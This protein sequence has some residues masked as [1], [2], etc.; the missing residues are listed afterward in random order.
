[1][2]KDFISFIQLAMVIISF[3]VAFI[4]TFYNWRTGWFGKLISI[5]LFLTT[6]GVYVSTL[7]A[8]GIMVNFPH[9]FRTGLMVLY[10]IPAGIY[11]GIRTGFAKV[12]FHT[13]DLFHL[14]PA[15]FYIVNFYPSI[16][17][18]AAV[19][20]ELINPKNMRSFEEGIIF[21]PY[22]VLWITEVLLFFYMAKIYRE[23][24]LQSNPHIRPY[25]QLTI[26]LL[27]GFLGIQ[28]MPPLFAILGYYDGQH[29][30]SFM[31][32]YVL[33]C[34]SF[35]FI[36]LSRP[37]IIYGK[38]IQKSPF[39]STQSFDTSS[40]GL[41]KPQNK[42]R[43]NERLKTGLNDSPKEV[44]TSNHTERFVKT[45]DWD[46]IEKY[47]EE[48]MAYLDSSFTQHDLINAT[49]LTPFQIR[50]NLKAKS[51]A[52]FTAYINEK[53]INYLLKKLAENPQWRNYKIGS[54]ASQSGFKSINSFYLIFKK[55][56]GVRPKEYIDNINKAV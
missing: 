8:T 45:L 49:G 52:N 53:R 40:K 37:N 25:N 42:I 13:T 14:V 38:R 1:M 6:Y 17:T 22:A 44:S 3:L 43:V 19:K 26:I 47:L 39:D 24:I 46:K 29:R 2:E 7:A 11:I 41:F 55:V 5:V 31:I 27:I 54:L 9:T 30:L 10:F 32:I 16:F 20:R 33:T 15:L 50:A 23:F 21:A 51:K 36:L 56:T 34:I 28:M 12:P 35:Y 48:S 18:S 4:F